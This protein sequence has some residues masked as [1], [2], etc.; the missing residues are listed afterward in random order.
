MPGIII[1]IKIINILKDKSLQAI[2]NKKRKFENTNISSS[3][4]IFNRTGS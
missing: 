4:F 3:N 2:E 1:S